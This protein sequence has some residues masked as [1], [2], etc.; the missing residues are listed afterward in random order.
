MHKFT[1]S[2][3]D[4]TPITDS[5]LHIPVDENASYSADFIHI[6]NTSSSA[7]TFK[8]QLIK[9]SMSNGS[10]IQMCFNGNCL[11]DTISPILTINAGETYTAFDLL[12]SYDNTDES[13]VLVH[14]VDTTISN[15]IAGLKVKYNGD[16][17]IP[18]VER[19]IPLSLSAYPNP[20]TSYSTIKYSVPTKYNS[21]KVVVRNMLG[22]V[23]KTINVKGGT[24]GKINLNTTDLNN[25]VYFYS[26]IADGSV[27]SAK[28]LVVKH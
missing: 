18:A 7:I 26:I 19:V 21:A 14:L 25:G 11:E 5:V 13:I 10:T 28:K 3:A 17:A 23:V 9:Q 12:Y 20:A 27:L 2:Y 15:V 1:F 16:F 4:G 6:T 24:T 8:V 22:S